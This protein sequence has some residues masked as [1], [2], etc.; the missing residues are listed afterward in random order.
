MSNTGFDALIVLLTIL[1]V[2]GRYLVIITVFAAISFALV[3]YS[4]AAG[5]VVAGVIAALFGIGGATLIAQI[6]RR[7][8]HHDQ[9]EKTREIPSSSRL[10]EA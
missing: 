10:A 3:A 8:R 2:V 9:S 6:Y 7:Q 4:L 1:S 5:N